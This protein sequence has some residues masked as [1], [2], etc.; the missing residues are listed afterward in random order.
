MTGASRPLFGVTMALAKYASSI[1]GCVSQY[2]FP[3]S[4]SQVAKRNY[5]HNESVPPVKLPMFLQE[6]Q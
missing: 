6:A 2:Y 1:T 3:V 5:I 4:P